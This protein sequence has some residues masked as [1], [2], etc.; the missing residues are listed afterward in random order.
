M[1]VHVCIKMCMKGIKVSKIGKG[2]TKFANQIPVLPSY[3]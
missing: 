1:N 3:D 2:K